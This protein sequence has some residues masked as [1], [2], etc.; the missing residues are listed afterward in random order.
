M[1]IFKKTIKVEEN[2]IFNSTG[3]LILTKE[4]CYLM[5]VILCVHAAEIPIQSLHVLH[6]ELYRCG[7]S[8]SFIELKQAL[9]YLIKEG[10]ISIGGSFN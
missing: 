8:V 2:Q 4:N 10:L 7:V 5:D 6:L 3:E 1:N 9:Q